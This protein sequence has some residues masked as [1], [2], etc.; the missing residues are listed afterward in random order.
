MRRGMVIVCNSVIWRNL[1]QFTVTYCDYCDCKLPSLVVSMSGIRSSAMHWTET[2][3][4]VNQITLRRVGRSWAG[5]S[6]GDIHSAPTRCVFAL[7]LGF[8]NFWSNAPKFRPIGGGDMCILF[9]ICEKRP[10]QKCMGWLGGVGGH[11]FEQTELQIGR[12]TGR[13]SARGTTD[14][15]E[16]ESFSLLPPSTRVGTPLGH[17]SPCL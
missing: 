5:I 13:G 8:V 2:V 10:F 7:F 12:C 16:F 15:S 3:L 1:P 4:C 11:S 14:Y 6:L 17:T 9:E